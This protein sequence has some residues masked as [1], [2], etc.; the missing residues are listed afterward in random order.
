MRG[1]DLLEKMELTDEK[2]I[3]AANMPVKKKKTRK[4]IKRIIK[5]YQYS[6]TALSKSKMRICF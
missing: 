5:R 4:N 2:Y 6:V 3:Q 1:K